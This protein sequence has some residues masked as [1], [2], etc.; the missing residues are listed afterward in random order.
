MQLNFNVKQQII[1]LT[2]TETKVVEKSRN[3]LH[4]AFNFC[5]EWDN[6]IKT[7]I[8]I[9]A[10]GDVF[11]VILEND[12]CAVPW[13]V[14]KA[15]YFSVSVFG[16]DLITANKI[17]VT[18]IKSGYCE[19]KTPTEPTPDVYAQ[20]LKLIEEMGGEVDE[21]LIKQAVT[22]YLEEHP[23]EVLPETDPTV[24]E[25][26]KQPTKPKYTAGEV[27]A[28]TKDETK[29]YVKGETEIIKS[30]LEGIQ[31]Q[32]EVEAHFRGYFLNDADLQNTPATPNDFAYSAQSGTRWIF[33]VE[34][35]WQNTETPVPDQLTSPSDTTPLINGVAFVGVENAYARGDHRHPTDTTRLS[36]EEFN[37]FKSE[38]EAAFDNIISIQNSLMGVSE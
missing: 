32:I 27:G 29:E 21:E 33:D 19:G 17:T 5:E 38:L 4:C 34:N 9:S 6:K 18:V 25:W 15:P 37:Q 10:D 28:Y 13:E 14:I 24:P 23:V 2:D 30:D 7:A 22:E 1:T 11:N 35:G 26:A 31:S 36:V 12:T 20:I 3:Y 16:G 8:F